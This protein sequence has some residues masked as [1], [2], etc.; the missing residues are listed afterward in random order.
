LEH[1]PETVE[2]WPLA[3]IPGKLPGRRQ[4]GQTHGYLGRMARND[5][6]SA[7]ELILPA[8]REGG[9]PHA[10]CEKARLKQD[11]SAFGYV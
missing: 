3:G 11:E 4:M 6:Q 9:E 7:S 5:G 1:C 10:T 2:G 8:S